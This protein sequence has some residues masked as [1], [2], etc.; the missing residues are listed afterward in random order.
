MLL[1][2]AALLGFQSIKQSFFPDSTRPQFYV[3][4]WF[5]NGT[6]IDET[7]REIARAEK[8]LLEKEEILRVATEIGGGQPRFL[9][10]YT[11][12]YPNDAFARILVDVADYKVILGLSRSLQAELEQAFPQAVP[13]VRLFVN[14]PSTGG[15]VQLR[16]LGPDPA[17]VRRLGE[18]AKA[19]LLAEPRAKAVRDEWGNKVKVL[20]PLLA[21]A[22]ARRAGID[23]PDVA[24]AV[25]AAVEGT[26]VGVYREDDELLP[27]IARAPESERSDLDSLGAIPV[28]SPAAQRMIPLDQVVSG[29]E[30]G[31]E[32]P[33]IWRRDRTKM[34]RIHADARYGLPSELLAA[35]KPEIEKALGADLQAY[36]GGAPGTPTLDELTAGTIGIKFKDLIPLAGRDGYYMAWGGEAE[37]SADSQA[38]LA[39]TIPIFFGLMVLIVLFLFNSI[40]KTLII[41][42]TV[43]LAIIGVTAGLL[44]FRQPFGF[45]A[46]LGLMSLAGMLIK[47]AIVLI[48]QIDAELAAGKPGFQ[49]IVDSGVSRLIPVSMAALTTI[50][51]M[52]PLL[53]DAFFV[54]M[55][56]TIMFGLGFATILTL[57]VVP[58]LYAIFFRVPAAAAAK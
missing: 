13:N 31:F 28:W 44:M 17:E 58:V 37:D 10:T 30:V 57:I 50:L 39:K 12:E 18:Q 53:K 56:V 45:M 55:A 48:D 52:I 5:P 23:R 35:V 26:Q 27:I 47:N 54:S 33:Y 42:L 3:D 8:L 34:L 46:L 6:H 38:A 36:F 9:L 29:F 11:P 1:F 49:A 21:E 14:G 20:Q 19:I 51:G 7:T 4:F 24:Q 41:W 22:Q 32:D 40:K 25:Q 16:I 43:P 15:K 2:V